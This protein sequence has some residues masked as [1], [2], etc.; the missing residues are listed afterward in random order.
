MV[1]WGFVTE[2]NGDITLQK[3]SQDRPVPMS[4]FA[5]QLVSFV[6][7][8]LV[9][10]TMKDGQFLGETQGAN[11]VASPVCLGMSY[12]RPSDGVVGAKVF[13]VPDVGG[14][15]CGVSIPLI[16]DV[17]CEEMRCFMELAVSPR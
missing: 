14:Q 9:S 11:L 10:R 13:Q 8:L 7:A 3:G 6:Q 12:N 5:K 4:A 15:R 1:W 16:S 17:L 2:M